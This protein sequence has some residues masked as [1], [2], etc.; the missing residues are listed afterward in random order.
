MTPELLVVKNL[1]RTALG[2][3]KTKSAARQYENRIAELCASG[4]DVGNFSH[5][6]E[7]FVDMMKVACTHIDK[8]VSSYL[9]E[10]LPN[11]GIVPHFYI[12]AD[13]STNH[14]VTNQ[15]C[16]ICP[17]VNGERQGILLSLS[18][19]YTDAD[20]AGGVGKDLAD[21]VY[22]DL[23]SHAGLS[24]SK[25]MA[26]QGRVMDGQ[27]L[28]IPFIEAINEPILQLL[29]DDHRKIA[30]DQFWWSCEWDGAHWLDKVFEKFKETL[31][32]SRLLGKK[33]R[34]T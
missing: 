9:Q 34:A 18:P 10:P 30:L 16:V 1:L 13:K 29:S 26:A 4:G 5:S 20:G 6:R 15:A 25:L 14:R 31:F 17:V 32:V 12:T 23:E 21:L 22:Q 27:Y 3:V 28:T 8:K 7:L 2:V 11:T 33:Y 19:V 24:G